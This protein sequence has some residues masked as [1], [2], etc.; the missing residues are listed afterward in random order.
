MLLIGWVMLRSQIFSK[1]AGY[2]GIAAGVVSL[3]MYVPQV[4][5]FISI[6]SAVSMQVWYV[7][8]ALA[9]LRLRNRTT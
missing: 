2:V 4:G 3:G 8:I 9:L 5:A 1:A 6:L 7:M